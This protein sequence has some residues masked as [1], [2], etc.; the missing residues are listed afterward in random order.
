MYLHSYWISRDLK[1]YIESMVSLICLR[2]S[3]IYK[4]GKV[5]DQSLGRITSFTYEECKGE[6]ILMLVT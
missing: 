1:S 5:L 3:G 4:N 2:M 6:Q